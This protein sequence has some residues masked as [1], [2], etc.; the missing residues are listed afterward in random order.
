[1]AAFKLSSKLVEN[2]SLPKLRANVPHQ[3]ILPSG[4]VVRQGRA[5]IY[6]ALQYSV[7]NRDDASYQN[8]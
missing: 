7:V 5:V 1:M 8:K 6:T 3:E 2:C 4:S